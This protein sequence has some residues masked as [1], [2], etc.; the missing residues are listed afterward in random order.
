[1]GLTVPKEMGSKDVYAD[2]TEKGEGQT[3]QESNLSSSFL[4]RS[5]GSFLAALDLD[6]FEIS[7]ETARVL[8]LCLQWEGDFVERCDFPKRARLHGFS[9][10]RT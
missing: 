2:A 9:S 5:P 8:Q 7:I 1:M 3:I 4:S 6:R 10:Q